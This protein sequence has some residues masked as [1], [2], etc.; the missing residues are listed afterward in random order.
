MA[1]SKVLNAQLT[2][3]CQLYHDKYCAYD[4]GSSNYDLPVIKNRL[5]RTA[6]AEMTKLGGTPKAIDAIVSR[7]FVEPIYYW[8]ICVVCDVDRTACCFKS[9][10]HYALC[11]KCMS[12]RAFTS[13]QKIATCPVCWATGE[14]EFPRLED[15]RTKIIPRQKR[16]Y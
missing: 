9:C 7:V 14:I 13:P 2:R 16:L 3:V 12:M 4:R 15:P 1:S 11:R 6:R 8:D 5:V 10:R